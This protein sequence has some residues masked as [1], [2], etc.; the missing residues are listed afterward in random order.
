MRKRKT[1]WGCCLPRT[2]ATRTLFLLRCR[3][4]ARARARAKRSIWTASSTHRRASGLLQVQGFNKL[5]SD[6]LETENRFKD[7]HNDHE[8]DEA[9]SRTRAISAPAPLFLDARPKKRRRHRHERSATAAGARSADPKIRCS[10]IV[11]STSERCHKLY[12]DGCMEKRY[13]LASH[14]RRLFD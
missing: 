14:H 11:A 3:G 7:D 2:G 8:S 9:D 4:W 12:C 10:V 1:S 13:V 5:Y 6:E